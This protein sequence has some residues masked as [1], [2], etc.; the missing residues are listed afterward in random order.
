MEKGSTLTLSLPCNNKKL[1]ILLE[2]S[3]IENGNGGEYN[4]MSKKMD[5]VLFYFHLLF[6]KTNL[7]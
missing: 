7:R 6:L 1:P 4:K 2:A 5:M 3:A